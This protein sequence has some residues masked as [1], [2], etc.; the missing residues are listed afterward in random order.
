MIKHVL[1]SLIL[2]LIISLSPAIAKDFT[3]LSGEWAPYVSESLPGGGPTGQIVTEAMAAVGHTVQFKYVPW[4]RTEV[5][6]QAGKS[7]ATF[8][9]S[10]TS[11]FEKTCYLSSPLAVQK[12]VFFYL[13]S[14]HPGWDYTDLNALK[15]LKVGGSLGYSYV[16]LFED[17][18]IK[19]SYAPT[20]EHSLKKLISERIDVAPESQLVGWNTI[21]EKFSSD[22][23]KIASSETALF[24]KPLYLMV[25][26]NH[27]QGKELFDAF[28]KGFKMI[29]DNGRYRQ[30]L[31]KY[32]LS[33]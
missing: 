29:K 32:G 20:I 14:K 12:M 30:I 9:W 22:A 15:R 6:T 27:P 24:K 33:D 26:K 10:T 5:M 4:K 31:D 2:T 23:D 16:Q 8:P 28:E 25:S 1:L 3:I 21:K 18:G 19:A 11:E 13:K 17:A 7:I